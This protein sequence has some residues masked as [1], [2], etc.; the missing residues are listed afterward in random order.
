MSFIS[1]LRNGVSAA[2]INVVRGMNGL[3]AT[4]F[5]GVLLYN[6]AYPQGP[7]T[8][9]HPGWVQAIAGVLWFS[10]VHYALTRAKPNA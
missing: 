3:A 9:L 6:A 10:L 5:G 2:W 7:L 8:F 4:V 1:A